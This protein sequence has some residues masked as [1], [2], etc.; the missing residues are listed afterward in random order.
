[1]FKLSWTNAGQPVVKLGY[2]DRS[3]AVSGHHS[4]SAPVVDGGV[5]ASTFAELSKI[6][7]TK[8]LSQNLPCPVC[9]IEAL[10]LWGA[11]GLLLRIANNFQN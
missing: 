11:S 1:M 6:S 8:V 10:P 4:N 7:S 5:L 2:R 9:W 3:N